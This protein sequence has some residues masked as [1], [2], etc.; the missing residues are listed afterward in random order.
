MMLRGAMLFVVTEVGLAG[1]LDV[2]MIRIWKGPAA[3]R[4]LFHGPSWRSDIHDLT[5]IINQFIYAIMNSYT[6]LYTD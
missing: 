2:M 4:Q 1:I 3:D 5:Q 6:C